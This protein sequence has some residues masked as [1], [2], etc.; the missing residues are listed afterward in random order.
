VSFGEDEQYKTKAIFLMKPV[1]LI[2]FPQMTTV[3]IVFHRRW[4]KCLGKLTIS[5]FSG[6]GHGFPPACCIAIP[7]KLPQGFL[8]TLM[9]LLK[10]WSH[11][12]TWFSSIT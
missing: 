11:N 5:R 8:E 4:K 10:L 2:L 3:K 9:S 1:L 7:C 12:S 6:P